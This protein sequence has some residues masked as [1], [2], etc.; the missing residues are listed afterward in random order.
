MCA[1]FR[2]ISSYNFLSLCA[3][4]KNMKQNNEQLEGNGHQSK[5]HS[6]PWKQ[7]RW[8]ICFVIFRQFLHHQT[9]RTWERENAPRL[10]V[11]RA[12]SRSTISSVSWTAATCHHSLS[13]V[14]A[15]FT[16]CKRKVFAIHQYG[17]I[18]TESL[19]CAENWYRDHFWTTYIQYLHLQYDHSGPQE[20][21]R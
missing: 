19:T 15:L 6:A 14:Q 12:P 11:C 21:L 5:A 1:L 7:Q 17:N 4:R 2:F 20:L 18:K 9:S 8:S 3:L 10:P 16:P 13:K